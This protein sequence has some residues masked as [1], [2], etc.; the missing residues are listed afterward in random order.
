MIDYAHWC[1]S[2]YFSMLKIIISLISNCSGKYSYFMFLT[3]YAKAICVHI[4]THIVYLIFFN[5]N[6]Y[7]LYTFMLNS[8]QLRYYE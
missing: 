3:S 2:N 7:V 1:N 5:T 4:Y 6:T 8:P